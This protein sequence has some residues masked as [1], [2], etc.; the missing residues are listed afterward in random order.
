MQTVLNKM[1]PAQR[2]KDRLVVYL[3]ISPFFGFKRTQDVLNKDF[4]GGGDNLSMMIARPLF[5]LGALYQDTGLSD[6]FGAIS[7][8]NWFS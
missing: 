6:A 8:S 7:P 1:R 4:N 2:H 3:A 5:G